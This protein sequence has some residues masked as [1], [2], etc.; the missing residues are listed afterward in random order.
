MMRN[1]F[2]PSTLKRIAVVGLVVVLF[3][4]G[5]GA[6][7]K[8]TV[9]YLLYWDA[10][11][12]AESWARYVAENVTDLEDIAAGEQ[13]SAES[14][15]F[16]IRTQQIRY[17]FGFEIVDFYGNVQLI[18]DGSKISSLY[19]SVHSDT[20][21]RAVTLGEPIISVNEGTPP[22]RP[23]IYSEA[24]LP[25]IID[26]RPWAV[27]AAFV[28]LTEQRDHFRKAFLL[29]A[30]ALCLLISGAVGI[31]T[32]AWYRRT[33]EKQGADRRIRYLAHHDVLTGLANRAHLIE[34]LDKALAA[35]PV[36]GNSLAVHFIDLDHFKGINDAFG[37]D[38]GDFLLKTFAERLRAVSRVEDVIARLG[39][40]EFV[41]IQTAVNSRDEAEKFAHRLVTALTAPVRFNN[42]ELDVTSSVGFALAPADGNSSKRLLK[43]ADLAL[44]KAKADGRNCV[45]YFLPEMDATLQARIELE[46]TIRNAVVHEDFVLHYQPIFE[47]AEHRLVGFEALIRLP[48]EDG[49]LIPPL[50]F[51]PVAEELRLIGKIGAWV[52]RQACRTASTWPSHLTVAV[53]MSVAQFEAGSV[54]DIVSAALEEA[55]LEPRRLELEVT[56]SLLLGDSESIM[57]ELRTLKAMGVA[58][59]MDDFGTGYSSLSYLWRFPFDKIKIDRSF[60]AGLNRSGRNSETVVKTI[61]AL[62]RQL[63]MRVTVEGVETA[64]QAAFVRD[65]EGDQAQGYFFGRPMPADEIA[66]WILLD[67]QR[68]NRESTPAAKTDAKLQLIK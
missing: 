15:A 18:S 65:A 33:K 14:M 23:K 24:Y 57:M 67:F 7:L 29:A 38:S 4:I 56:E 63:H 1:P 19:G 3:V 6:V 64:R 8:T 31:P 40:D 47:I 54:C 50:V 44:Y 45:R 52:L 48:A 58:I 66:A 32:I 59:V 2:T 9:D 55:E 35:L 11:A 12:A 41:V 51:I 28:D 20:A 22:V 21:A 60:M 27:V 62:G 25:V 39:G 5:V 16:L 17:V 37:H 26:G 68:A 36:R 53:N 30:L 34:T 43:S 10:T 42:Y 46:K 61:I 49:S 13:P